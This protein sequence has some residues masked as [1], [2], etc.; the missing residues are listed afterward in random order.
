MKKTF[1]EL[2][3]LIQ[4]YFFADHKGIPIYEVVD[5]VHEMDMHSVTVWYF[6]DSNIY[7]RL[8]GISD[9]YGGVEEDVLPDI[10]RVYRKDKVVS[11]YEP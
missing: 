1:E 10:D 5:H 7:V 8:T 4:K 6:P 2:R 9:S 3:Y 11:Y